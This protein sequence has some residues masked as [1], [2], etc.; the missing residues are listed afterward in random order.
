[1]KTHWFTIFSILANFISSYFKG[2][3]YPC[4]LSKNNSTVQEKCHKLL[5][6]F[7]ITKHVYRRIDIKV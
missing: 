3:L 6:N 7:Q 5:E 4:V 1:M 2:T